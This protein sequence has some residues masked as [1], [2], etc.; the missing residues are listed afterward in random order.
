MRALDADPESSP[1]REALEDVSS[2]L[3]LE[4]LSQATLYTLQIQRPADLAVDRPSA[5]MLLP[6]ISQLRQSSQLCHVSQWNHR[7]RGF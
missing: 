7:W 2:T 3:T 1:L 6:Q 5:S 4:Q